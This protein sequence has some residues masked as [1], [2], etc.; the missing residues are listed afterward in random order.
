[1]SEEITL[2]AN[3][4]KYIYNKDEFTLRMGIFFDG[5][6]NDPTNKESLSNIRKL[7]IKYPNNYDVANNKSNITDKD[8]FPNIQSAYIR[9]VGSKNKSGVKDSF[10]GGG[11]GSGATERLEGILF[12]I[13]SMIEIY[14]EKKGSLP[15][16]IELDI[17]GFSRGAAMAR[18]FVNILKQDNGSFYNIKYKYE[19][20][21]LKIRTLNLFD[22]VGSMG[23]AGNDIDIGF[24]YHIKS[25][26]VS[27]AIT[28]F[29]ADD[30]YRYN[31]DGQFIGGNYIPYPIDKKI[32]KVSEYVLLG[33]HSDIGGGYKKE[34]HQVENNDLSKVYLHKMYDIC[35]EVGI[36]FL[37]KPKTN[38]WK[39]PEDLNSYLDYFDAMYKDSKHKNLKIAHKK[40]REQQTYENDKFKIAD[41]TYQYKEGIYKSLNE[42]FNDDTL[43]NEFIKKSNEFH[44]KY[45][46]ISYT[47]E[48]IKDDSVSLAQLSEVNLIN[49]IADIKDYITM[50]SEEVGNKLQ[51]TYFTPKY[52]DMRKSTDNANLIEI[53]EKY[54]ILSAIEFK[55]F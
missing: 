35:I 30:E 51:R 1:M 36:P 11:F 48:V 29:I 6:G 31:F 43:C 2:Y 44:D 17:F 47:S 28:H 3:D 54:T 39:I 10:L 52:V 42:I 34:E 5:T 26:Y 25:S 45:I 16:S 22:T 37:E 32:G 24:T 33:A 46:H 4:V 55:D 12:Y 38:A 50:G 18:H 15:E 14:K 13:Q 21:N 49:S 7:F 41:E 27:D 8:N 19:A 9:G 23:I 20:N 53:N 40:L